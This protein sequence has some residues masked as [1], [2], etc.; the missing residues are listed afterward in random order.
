M[1]P[2]RKVKRRPT[3][4]WW[5]NIPRDQWPAAVALVDFSPATPEAAQAISYIASIH[6]GRAMKGDGLSRLPGRSG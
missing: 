3:S 6:F 5:V 1:A 2:A 4:S